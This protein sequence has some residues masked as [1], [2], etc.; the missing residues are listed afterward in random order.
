MVLLWLTYLGE[1]GFSGWKQGAEHAIQRKGTLQRYLKRVWG[2]NYPGGEL[3]PRAEE[4]TDRMEESRGTRQCQC[5]AKPWA[6]LALPCKGLDHSAGCIPG[7]SFPQLARNSTICA[8]PWP[9]LFV[10]D[11]E[12]HGENISAPVPG[13]WRVPWWSSLGC[14]HS[15]LWCPLCCSFW[16]EQAPKG[17]FWKYHPL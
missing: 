6:G 16:Q 13:C 7:S 11:K 3:Q 5:Q 10:G 9:S 17:Q 12:T 1:G 15:L 4:S 2:S 14:Q 8:L